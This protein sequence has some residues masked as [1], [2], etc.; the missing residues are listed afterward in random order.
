MAHHPTEP[1][2]MVNQVEAVVKFR[3]LRYSLSLTGTLE[4]RSTMCKYT[5]WVPTERDASHYVLN[6]YFFGILVS[7]LGCTVPF[8]INVDDI[9]GRLTM[10]VE[11]YLLIVTYKYAVSGEL[12]VLPYNTALDRYLLYSFIF[13]TIAL[14]GIGFCNSQADSDRLQLV[15][16]VISVC[17]HLYF[18][19]EVCVSVQSR[20]QCISKHGKIDENMCALMQQ[21][22]IELNAE[23]L[24]TDPEKYR[25]LLEGQTISEE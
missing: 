9:S 24:V 13:I 8:N 16:I 17:A 14:E 1:N 10:L 5:I 4:S 7:V 19:I 23:G 18:A 25:R 2:V 22:G 15:L 6:H 20:L 3:P 12:P 21:N 11:L